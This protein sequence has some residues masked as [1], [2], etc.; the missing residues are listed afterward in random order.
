MKGFSFSFRASHQEGGVQSIVLM[1]GAYRID[2]HHLCTY[3]FGS[4]ND[5]P[6]MLLCFIII[7][8][9]AFPYIC[10]SYCKHFTTL[11]IIIFY[12]VTSQSKPTW[13]G[14]ATY[15]P[16]ASDATRYDP[17]THL[18]VET[19]IQKNWIISVWLQQQQQYLFSNF[20]NLTNNPRVR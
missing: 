3:H 15:S 4:K 17:S 19:K 16:P 5:A 12:C 7:N 2:K 13:A 10:H 14:R 1:E 20:P 6:L 11:R 8:I 9:I 18:V